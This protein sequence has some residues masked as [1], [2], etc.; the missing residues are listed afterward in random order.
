MI[1]LCMIKAARK[2]AANAEL[3]RAF[4]DIFTNRLRFVSAVNMRKKQ[5]K[6]T[7]VSEAVRDSECLERA[8]SV[9]DAAARVA[10][11]MLDCS[12][13]SGRKCSFLHVSL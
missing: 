4:A 9:E 12:E 11:Y 2:G 7:E 8:E 6:D 13:E 3:A 5:R 1:E 10:S